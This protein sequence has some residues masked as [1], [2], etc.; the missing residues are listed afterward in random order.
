MSCCGSCG[1][2]GKCESEQVQQRPTQIGGT[3][4]R[5]RGQTPVMLVKSGRSGSGT[6]SLGGFWDTFKGVDFDFA[7]SFEAG[8]STPTSVANALDLSKI[9][10][11][12]I[13][14]IPTFNMP[15]VQIPRFDSGLNLSAATHIDTKQF[16]IPT[17][18]IRSGGSSLGAR[19][20][21]GRVLLLAA[22]GVGAILAVKHFRSKPK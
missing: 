7:K 4:M 2:G 17:P 20:G 18:S 10:N 21:S 19:S 22:L 1:H 13:P 6:S 8:Y 14:S 15:N 9:P 12:Q 16:S 3:R 5:L 11:V